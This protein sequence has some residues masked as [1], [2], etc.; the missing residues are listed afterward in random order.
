MDADVAAINR[1]EAVRSG[2]DYLIDG[3]TYRV[4]PDG[5]AFPVSGTGVHRLD[6]GAFRALGV[7]DV[8]G[9]MEVAERMLDAMAMQPV[10]RAA[11]LAERG[12]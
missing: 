4:K 5:T 9:L 12:M 2:D 7:Y 3:R 6:R 1:G 11:Y 8:H 10:G